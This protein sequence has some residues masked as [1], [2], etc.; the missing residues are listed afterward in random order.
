MHT[1]RTTTYLVVPPSSV[2]SFLPASPRPRSGRWAMTVR[3]RDR[4]EA[5]RVEV[6]RLH[7]SRTAPARAVD[8]ATMIWL[9]SQGQGHRAPRVARELGVGVDA[10]RQGIKRC[11]AEGLD[12]LQAR[13]RSGCPPPYTPEPVGE[14][15][16]VAA[17]KPATRGLPCGSWTL[18]RLAAYLAQTKGIPIKR[19]RLNDRLVVAGWRWRQAETGFGERVDPQLAEQ[20]GRSSAGGGNCPPGA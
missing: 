4:T 19:S 1:L 12:G 9:G 16:A 13:P 15:S 6:A 20:R 3:V 14:V 8:R 5:E 11:N 18:D 2:A 7:R 10:V 17:T